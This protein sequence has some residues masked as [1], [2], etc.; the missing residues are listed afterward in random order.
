MRVF[1]EKIV[2][3]VIIERRKLIEELAS[4]T[5]AEKLRKTAHSR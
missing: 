4:E 2:D 1:I 5:Y 3:R